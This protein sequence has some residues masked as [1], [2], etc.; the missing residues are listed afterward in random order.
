MDS[1]KF[2]KQAN[3]LYAQ[4]LEE[5]INILKSSENGRYIA[6]TNGEDVV[7][8]VSWNDVPIGI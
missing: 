8:A 5:T 1:Q 6:I 4:A 3:D 7:S 2:T